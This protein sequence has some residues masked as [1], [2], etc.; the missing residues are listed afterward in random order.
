MLPFLLKPYLR[1][2]IWG[3][4][5]LARFKSLASP[6]DHVGE[7]WEVSAMPGR[8][9]V[10]GSGPL[11]G[12]PLSE[13]CRRYGAELLGETAYLESHGEFPLLIKFI[14]AAEDLSVQVHPTEELAA[15]LHGGHGKCEMWYIIESKPGSRLG[16]GLR[17]QLTPDDFDR[18]VSDGTFND[19]MAW[20]ETHAGDSFYLPA[21]R[22]HAIGAGNLLLEVQ[23]PSD[24]TYRIYDYDRR[25]SDGNLRELHIDQA[26]QAID[27]RVVDNYRVQPNGDTLVNEEHFDVKRLTV[28]GSRDITAQKV[29]A[30]LCISGDVKA[31]LADSSTLDLSRGHTMLL[32]SGQ[33]INLN[34]HAI[35]IIVTP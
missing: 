18:C 19:A 28:D 20:Y 26:R 23:Q 5:A 6:L 9:S 12:M 4:N 22:V 34:G 21:G 13:V 16:A 10:V 32:P 24:I 30:V 7:S 14:D 27:Y 31:T 1:K 11:Q 29:T 17:T 25:D 15:K 3:G 2:V 8:E 33:K 35:L